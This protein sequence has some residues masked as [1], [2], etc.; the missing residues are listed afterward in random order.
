MA[1]S[2]KQ[3]R[4]EKLLLE[5][6]RTFNSTLEYEELNQLVLKLIIAAV[7]S[8][9]ALITRSDPDRPGHRTRFMH[10]SDCRMVTIDREP[11]EGVVGWVLQNCEPLML[12]DAAHDPRVDPELAQITGFPARSIL[13]LPLIG[14]GKLIGVVEAM[15][16]YRPYREA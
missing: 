10:H 4:V 8:E 3:T 14:R 5:A 13:A 7:E 16:S 12:N 6:A 9:A 15:A 2:F 11:D 1:H